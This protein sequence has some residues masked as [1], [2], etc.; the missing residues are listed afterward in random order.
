MRFYGTSVGALALN[1]VGFLL[2]GGGLLSLVVAGASPAAAQELVL[3]SDDFEAGLDP[4][5]WHLEVI[6]G[7]QWIHATDADGGHVTT[8]PQS[9]RDRT[10]RFADMLS[11]QEC[12]GDFTLTWDMRFL[13]QGFHQ[14]RRLI[15]FRSEDQPVPHGY[16][17]QTAVGYPYGPTHWLMF[18]K[19][20]PD[21]SL[22]NLSAQIQSSWALHQWFSL[23]LEVKGNVF[24]LKFWEKEDAEP[25]SW[26]I[27]V[28]DPD[29]T[30]S[31]GRIGFGNY[32][33]ASTDVDNVTVS[34]LN[35]GDA[36]APCEPDPH[37]Q[38]YWHRQCLGVPASEGGIDPG[39]NGRGP[40]EPLE[41]SFTKD[42]MPAVDA[43]LQA[44]LFLFGS[45]TEGMDADPASDPC[46]RAK[47]Q[48][49]ALLFNIES[50]R[51]QSG[52]GVDVSAQGCGSL[53]VGDLTGELAGLIN[54]GEC[55]VAANCAAAINE[56]TALT[57]AA[58]AGL[59]V[60]ANRATETAT[61][62]TAPPAWSGGR[63][64]LRTDVSAQADPVTATDPVTESGVVLVAPAREPVEEVV[65]EE[66]AT[67]FE[68]IQRH[69]SVMANPSAPERATDVSRDSLLTTLSGGFDPELRLEI[70]KT[71]I[72][73]VDAS[74]H[75]LLAAHLEDIRSEAVDFGKD[76]LASEAERLLKRL[77]SAGK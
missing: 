22:V 34:A 43:L 21:G 15:Y 26:A 5:V 64:S 17:L 70:V 52:C 75:T 8:L 41:P 20:N 9:P 51:L 10:N 77:D 2:V 32:W 4:N 23:K 3:F 56:G 18:H 38:G 11:R 28:E 71:L 58:V 30:Y 50:N 63:S 19:F 46:E 36:C 42:L 69:L 29:S 12:F 25:E 57:E 66:V 45:C 61:D 55:D 74:Y 1:V 44:N 27:E 76:D 16:W 7:A 24:K 48:Y 33:S 37:S 13:N 14:D 67:E 31:T 49:T 68:T 53:T 72:H 59:V 39:R 62:L 60:Q 35:V 47:K 54:A 40:Q 65:S 6:N 73:R